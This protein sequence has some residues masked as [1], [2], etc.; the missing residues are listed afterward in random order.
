M[1]SRGELLEGAAGEQKERTFRLDQ[2]ALQKPE[3]DAVAKGIRAEGTAIK[4]ADPAGR[5]A[6]PLPTHAFQN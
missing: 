5:E 3:G 2:S 4:R 6:E 1:E